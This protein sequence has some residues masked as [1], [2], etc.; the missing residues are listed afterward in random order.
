MTASENKHGLPLSMTPVPGSESDLH[1]VLHSVTLLLSKIIGCDCAALVLPNEDG[2]SAR[3]YLLDLVCGASGSP[4]VRDVPIEDAALEALINGRKPQYIPDVTNEPATLHWL[5]QHTR[6]G[7]SSGAHVFPI[8]SPQRRPGILV[9]ITNSSESNSARN[10]E[11]MASA[12]VLISRFLDTALAFA[13]AESYKQNLARERDRL[14]LVLEISNHTIAHLDMD[15][16]FRAASKSLHEFFDTAL[17]GFWL[18]EQESNH[19]DLLT[20]DSAIALGF[21]ENTTTAILR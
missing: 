4:T 2:Q 1:A 16:L 13:A 15:A 17:T 20:L 3:L 12:A 11:L 9:F 10:R 8:A 6:I 5:L 18:F 7:P 19:L 14:K 21:R